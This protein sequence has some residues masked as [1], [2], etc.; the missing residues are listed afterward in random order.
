MYPY[1]QQT[2]HT[3]ESVRSST[4]MDWNRQ[5]AVF[6]RYPDEFPFIPLDN[7]SGLN[8]FFQLCAGLTARKVYAG[9][10]Y[11]LR[12]NPSAGA[13]YPCELYIQARDVQGLEDGIYHVEPQRFCLRL[14]YPL[15]EHEG[16]EACCSDK[17]RVSGLLLLVSAIYYRSSW[18]YRSRALR[19]CLLDSGHLLGAVESAAWCAGR[20]FQVQ[21]LLDRQ[22]V[23]ESFG[24]RDRELVMAMAVC[25]QREE[26]L[27]QEFAMQLPFVDGSGYHCTDRIIEK[28]Y[29]AGSR[30]A[31]C[32][33]VEEQGN[34]W[35]VSAAELQEAVI[36][37]RSIRE[38]TGT[39]MSR[40]EYISILHSV[41]EPV[42]SDCDQQV[43]LWSVVNR[44]DGLQPGL[45]EG[46]TCIRPGDFSDITGYLCLE[47]GLGADS[48]V[49][50][51]LSS[52]DSNYLPLMIKAGIIGQRIYL[53]ST[54]QGLG[55]SGI[56]AFYDDETAAF[57][58][59]D[60]MICY[61]LAVG[62]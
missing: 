40:D 55:C 62:Y 3:W 18:K 42:S 17:R 60:A 49:T 46:L 14:L 61:A 9:G 45:Y 23:A 8:D 31:G 37:R 43:R 53:A 21:Y 47:Q 6:K 58:Q 12:V 51:F 27:V 19:Y 2:V 25:G 11:Y 30:L 26:T 56:G 39:T 52:S 15:D 50:F 59:T 29:A 1:H 20:P 33:A 54:L 32:S 34:L 10:E 28:S 41:Q 35:S 48:G 24:F 38:F 7:L 22:R 36:S 4:T 57:L 13:L 5:P 44:V 16:L